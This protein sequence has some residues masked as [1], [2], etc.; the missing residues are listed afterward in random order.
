MSMMEKYTY[1]EKRAVI[2]FLNMI[3]TSD[4]EVKIEEL[5]LVWMLARSIHLDLND[6]EKMEEEAV[7][8]IMMNMSDEK[9]VDIIRMGYTLMGV[10][11]KRKEKEKKLIAS[12]KGLRFLNDDEFNRF[13]ESM[14]RPSDL[15]FL[16]KIVLILLAHYMAEVDG[17]IRQGEA[18]MLIVLCS[19]MEVNIEEVPLYRIPKDALYRAVFSMDKRVVK[20]IVEELLLISIADFKIA[21][22][23]YEF[24]FPILSHFNLDFEDILRHAKDRLKEHVEY[25]ELFRV[26]SPIN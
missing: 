23:E 22:Q 14:N 5:N 24:I 26:E 18:E 2:A 3:I 17:I 16:D 1:D 15:T 21:E 13:Y 11:Q 9:M 4:L 20:R 25:Y 6:V 10:D 7:R 8:T 12:I 19:L